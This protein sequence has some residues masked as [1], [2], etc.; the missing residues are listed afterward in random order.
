MMNNVAKKNSYVPKLEQSHTFLKIVDYPYKKGDL[1]KAKIIEATIHCMGTHGIEKCS[2]ELV[3]KQAKL[4]RAHVNY[5]F[6]EKK[7][8][9]K[10]AFAHVLMTAQ[11]FTVAGLSNVTE[12]KNLLKAYN[13]VTFAWVAAYAH[14]Q[15]LIALIHYYCA[16]QEEFK[17]FNTQA[18]IIAKERLRHL[19]KQYGVSASESEMKKKVDAIH[20]LMSGYVIEFNSTQHLNTLNTI[21]NDCW[22][23]IERILKG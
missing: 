8:L 3:G 18:R 11:Q 15:P 5:Y 21:K 13:D 9:F 1:K 22:E 23:N 4:T 20:G 6:K 7:D 19:V 17:V 10:A 2:F 16:V 14:H 12:P